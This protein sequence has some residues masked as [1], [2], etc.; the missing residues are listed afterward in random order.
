M[1]LTR[2]FY[3]S[4]YQRVPLPIWSGISKLLDIYMSRTFLRVI[5]C[6][7]IETYSGIDNKIRGKSSILVVGSY[8]SAS[9]R[10]LNSPQL[11]VISPKMLAVTRR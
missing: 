4:V 5:G 11:S 6:G 1:V 8:G 10:P 7:G 9:F 3:C 2:T